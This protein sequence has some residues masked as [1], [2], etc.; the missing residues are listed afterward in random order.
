M[1]DINL[2]LG[3]DL[4]VSPTGDLVLVDGPARGVQRIL[5][6]LITVAGTYLQNLGY[7]AGLP[8]KV[9]ESLDVD[10]IGALVRSQI[11]LEAAV[12]RDPDPDITVVPILNGVHV[13]VVYADAATGRQ[14]TLS[15]EVAP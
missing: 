5:R 10:A 7:G 2:P 11:F 4:S 1:P 15:F 3:G 8:R 14:Q 12:A 9:G 6:R 13:R